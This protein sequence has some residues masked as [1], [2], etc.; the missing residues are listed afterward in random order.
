MSITGYKCVG[1]TMFCI[2]RL[3]WQSTSAMW[4]TISLHE[5]DKFEYQPY[6]QQYWQGHV[7]TGFVDSA[8]S[9]FSSSDK[10]GYGSSSSSSSMHEVVNSLLSSSSEEEEGGTQDSRPSTGIQW[11]LQ[12]FHY[13]YVLWQ[14]C[15]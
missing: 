1:I 5:Y 2:W 9:I 10:D 13:L 8:V 12:L 6:T 4:K 3:Q 14:V 15:W 7:A 11:S